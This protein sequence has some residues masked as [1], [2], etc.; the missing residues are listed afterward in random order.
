MNL[1]RSIAVTAL[2][3][4][5]LSASPAFALFGKGDGYWG[6]HIGPIGI[7]SESNDGYLGPRIGP[8]GIPNPFTT[9]H[10]YPIGVL[11]PWPGVWP[12][13]ELPSSPSEAWNQAQCMLGA[14]LTANLLCLYEQ[15]YGY[16]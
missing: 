1:K 15:S 11:Y 8:I 9:Q 12:V 16:R 6:P 7:E 5:I 13:P 10:E 14:D 4:C 3:A 2:A